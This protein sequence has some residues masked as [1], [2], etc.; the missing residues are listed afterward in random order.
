M[1]TSLDHRENNAIKQPLDEVLG[2]VSHVRILRLLLQLAESPLGATMA[3]K[4]TG[5]SIP[6]VVKA[7]QRLEETGFV[8]RVGS[9]RSHQYTLRKQEPLVEALTQLYSAEHTRYDRFLGALRQAMEPV[10]ELHA[11]WINQMPSQLREPVVITVV[12]DAAA[13]SWIKKELRN[14]V[15][16][17]EREF[18]QTIEITAFTRSDDPPMDAE[19]LPL[20]LREFPSP[21]SPKGGRPPLH[22]EREERAKRMAEGIAELIKSDKSLIGRAM[23]HLNRLTHEGQ[24]TATA[25]LLEWRQI[26]ETYPSKRLRDFLVASSSRADR[27][28][29]SSP[30]FA[31]LTAEER[32]R[33]MAYLEKGKNDDA[34][35]T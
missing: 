12:T 27:L 9:G 10:R 20:L 34:G 19:A 7:L 1:G 29:Q 6:G 8:S 22:I 11:A 5:L 23:R 24:G 33:L 18:N 30:F 17:V 25:D 28:R 16:S 4:K 14:R 3:A 15:V 26:L 13:V 35:S 32:D 2:A 21:T 31:V